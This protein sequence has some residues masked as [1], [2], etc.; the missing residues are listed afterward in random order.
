MLLTVEDLPASVHGRILERAEGNPF[1]LEEIV[2][3]LIDAGRIVREEVRWRALADIEDVEIPDTVQA[4]LASRIDLLQ[5]PD[6]RALQLAAVV[7]RVFWPGSVARLLDGEREQLDETL[8]RLQDRELILARVSSSMARE[9]EF[10][11]KHTL[12]RDVAYETLPRRDRARAHA[13]VAR[14]IEERAGERR[15]E[16]VELLAHHYGQAYRAAE[17]NPRADV[18]QAERL[19]SRAFESLLAASADA[20]SKLASRK[21]QRLGEHALEFARNE[22]ER[23]LALAAMGYA[24]QDQYEGDDAWRCF[25]EAADARLAAGAESADDRLALAMLCAKASEIPTRWPGS[26]RTVPDQQVVRD[27]VDLGFRMIPAGDNVPRTRLL[28]ALA[29]WPWTFL[30]ATTDEGRQSALEAGNE[31][32]EIALRLERPDLASGALDGVGATLMTQER[33]HDVK[34]VVDRRLELLDRIDDL[35]EVGDILSLAS[36]VRFDLGMYDEAVEFATQGYERTADN[37]LSA[38]VHSQAWLAISRFRL[39][40]WDT[41]FEDLEV[42]EHH[43]G[44]RRGDPPYF[45]VRPY[46]AAALVY[47][48]RGERPAADRALAVVER[49]SDEEAGRGAIA[50]GFASLAYGRRGDFDTAWKRSDAALTN[51]RAFGPAVWEARCD[52]VAE[53]GAWDRAPEV[54]RASR[55][56]SEIGRLLALPAFADRLEGRAALT[57]GDSGRAIELL[58]GARNR[59]EELGARWERACTELSLAEVLLARG[60]EE[61]ARED[62]TRALPVFQELRSLR[63]LERTRELL[64][65]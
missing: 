6:K 44:D 55:E 21:A 32:A 9:E 38:A 16:F 33:F 48:V 43:L 17:Q 29:F 15:L 58:T 2:R 45:A 51:R 57:E 37:T 22:V 8:D 30:E 7:G 13:E 28:T 47:E 54:A 64:G 41:F 59:F 20:R 27:Y 3:H 23:S 11:F 19:R 14:W 4:V 52:L 49:G 1:F 12:T 34:E 26:M 60:D 62:L 35:L 31:A 40:Q 50:L 25:R 24:A 36:W 5:A 42:L 65:R 10:V 61:R 63:E 46:G 39:G 53:T 18:G 56:A